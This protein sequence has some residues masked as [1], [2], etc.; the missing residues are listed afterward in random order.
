MTKST[1]ATGFDVQQESLLKKR[2]RDD[3]VKKRKADVRARR[4]MAQV[5]QKKLDEKLKIA[6]GVKVIMPEVFVSN[7]MKQQRNYAKYKQMK[8]RQTPRHQTSQVTDKQ[9]LTLPREQ[10]VAPNSLLLV[11]RIK[12]SRTTTPQA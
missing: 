1:E 11:V 7:Y 2:K 4:R 3:L 12:E 10:R 6:G 9:E 8:A 5:R